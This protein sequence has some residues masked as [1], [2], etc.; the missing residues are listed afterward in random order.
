MDIEIQI[1]AVLIGRLA[2]RLGAFGRPLDEIVLD[3]TK[4]LKL[5]ME[6]RTPVGISKTSPRA[7]LSWTNA[8][9]VANHQARFTLPLPYGPVLEFGSIP[10]QR[11]WPR[12]GPRTIMSNSENGMRIFSRQA[13]GGMFTKAMEEDIDVD[14]IA[15][16]IIDAYLTLI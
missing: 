3:V 11:P 13:P 1:D 4:A 9:M 16:A 5:A 8:G 12:P 6:G 15:G 10:G 14:K 2:A 7:K